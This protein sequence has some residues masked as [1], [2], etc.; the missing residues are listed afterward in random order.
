[1]KRGIVRID[2]AAQAEV[3][4]PPSGVQ[5]G[6]GQAGPL[7]LRLFRLAGT[8]AVLAARVV[9]A[10]LLAIRVAAGGTAVQV[11]TS[12]P[13]L[14]E[15]LLR[16]DAGHV[17]GP[18]EVRQPLGGPTLVIDDRPPEARGPAEIRPWQC[19]LEIRT[20]WTPAMLGSFA[21]ADL[22]IFGAIPAEYSAGVA[23]AFGVPVAAAEVLARLDAGSFAVARRGRIEYVSL[24]P[25]A[26]EGQLLELA[27]G[28]MTGVPR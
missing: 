19:R 27:R 11:V 26:A 16:R 2:F 14:W 22:T 20:Q 28:P 3:T 21:H 17:V 18:A 1:V 10:Q 5:I 24:N 15:P 6:I 13:Q 12:R 4:A 8:R 7:T 25:T 23:K 9:P